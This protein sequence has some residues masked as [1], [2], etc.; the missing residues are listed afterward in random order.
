[1]IVFVNDVII[2]GKNIEEQT[3]SLH[4]CFSKLQNIKWSQFS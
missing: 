1:M 3:R 4:E 2:I